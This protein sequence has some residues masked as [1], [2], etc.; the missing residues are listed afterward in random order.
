LFYKN[1]FL[2]FYTDQENRPNLFKERSPLDYQRQ[3]DSPVLTQ[4]M[5]NEIQEAVSSISWWPY[6]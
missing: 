1:D 2:T 5:L 6:L 4:Q 3:Q